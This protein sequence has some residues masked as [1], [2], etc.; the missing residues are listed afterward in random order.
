MSNSTRSGRS[1]I[2]FFQEKSESCSPFDFRE[3]S[4]LLGLTGETGA[5]GNGVGNIFSCIQSG[6]VS[7]NVKPFTFLAG[8]C[9]PSSVS[10]V[11][12]GVMCPFLASSLS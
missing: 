10:M 3:G 6:S 5:D 2:G 9:F 11:V 1:P 4:R 7:A 12:S 8:A